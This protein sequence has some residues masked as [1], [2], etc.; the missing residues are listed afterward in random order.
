MQRL[1][2]P[3]VS[4]DLARFR[5]WLQEHNPLSLPESKFLED[6]DDLL[7]LKETSVPLPQRSEARSDLIPLCIVTMALFPLLCF[8]FITGVLN[9]MILL[10]ALLA[11]GLSSL[12][13]LDPANFEQH[14]QWLMACLGASL[15]AALI[16]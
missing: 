12:E 8:K 9:R 10:A 15:V 2:S 16:F 7:S 1:S 14:Q 3:A 11:A 5:T 4:A 13:R 6:D